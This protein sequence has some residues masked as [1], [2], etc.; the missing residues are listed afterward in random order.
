MKRCERAVLFLYIASLCVGCAKQEFAEECIYP[1]GKL[2]FNKIEF[3][4]GEVYTE[5]KQSDLLKVY[6]PGDCDVKL[7]FADS[8]PCVGIY[9]DE[10][11]TV[12]RIRDEFEIPARGGEIFCVRFEPKDTSS[13][14]YFAKALHVSID[15][16]EFVMPLGIFATIVEN[17][18]KLK[19]RAGRCCPKLK[20]GQDTVVLDTIRYGKRRSVVV[21]I[22]N[23]GSAALLI[24]KIETDC[25]CVV[26]GMDKRVVLPGEMEDLEISFTADGKTGMQSRT[27]RLYTNDPKQPLKKIVVKGYVI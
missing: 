24:R 20:V 16:R 12:N 17:P 4:W 21:P 6:N 3:E 14:G 5:Q 8:L 2:L 11:D 13:V 22:E 10:K 26:S 7:K 15:G 18:E 25:S 27:I 19:S 1:I 23:V 9:M